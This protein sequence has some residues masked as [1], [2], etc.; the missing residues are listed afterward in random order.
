VMESR[1][2]CHGTEASRCSGFPHLF[3]IHIKYLGYNTVYRRGIETCSIWK[4][5]GRGYRTAQ[6]R[7][8][9]SSL[10]FLAVVLILITRHPS[11]PQSRG[12]LPSPE[13]PQTRR[14]PSSELEAGLQ[15]TLIDD[16][17]QKNASMSPT[18]PSG[19]SPTTLLTTSIVLDTHHDPCVSAHTLQ[20]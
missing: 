10:V 4:R 17:G 9:Y 6:R 19:T 2:Y 16:R 1:C 5:Y 18:A 20:E 11:Q 12:A 3:R 7:I 15:P 13:L 14:P 8:L